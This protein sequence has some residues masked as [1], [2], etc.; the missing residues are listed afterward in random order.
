[1]V[2]DEPKETDETFKLNGFTML[3]EKSLLNEAKSFTIDYVDYGMR[4]GFTISSQISLTGSRSC[5]S[6]CSC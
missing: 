5:G 4:S 2:L 1:M 6:S 3:V